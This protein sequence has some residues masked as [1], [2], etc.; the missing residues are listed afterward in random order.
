MCVSSLLLLAP[1]IHAQ[2]SLCE[3]CLDVPADYQALKPLP[4]DWP[5]PG[6]RN[7]FRGAPFSMG[8][9][10]PINMRQT[11]DMRQM[12]ELRRAIRL[13]QRRT[14][15]GDETPSSAAS[16]ADA[17]SPTDAASPANE[18]P[19]GAPPASDPGRAGA[20]SP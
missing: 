10:G 2:E 4:T 19:A 6:N 3:P 1:A 13:L 14:P 7:Y 11:M 18:R 9:T 5:V 16:P 17:A 12:G 15:V 20:E 8:A